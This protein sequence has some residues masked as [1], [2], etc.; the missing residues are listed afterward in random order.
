MHRST[1]ISNCWGDHS[2]Y[3]MEALKTLGR[4]SNSSVT[5]RQAQDYLKK[6][7][8][9]LVQKND[10]LLLTGIMK[11][12]VY[13]NLLLVMI[14]WPLTIYE[15]PLSWVKSVEAYIN[16]YLRK[17]QGVSKNMSNVFL[18]CDEMSCPFQWRK[19]GGLLQLQ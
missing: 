18:Y 16:G 2:M 13:E 14:E 10:K 4:L 19:V 17:R 1:T 9:E 6:K 12:W 3:P 8:M 15:I 5:D 7:I 11:V